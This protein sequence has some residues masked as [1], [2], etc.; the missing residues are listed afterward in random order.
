MEDGE[1]DN[2]EWEPEEQPSC[3]KKMSSKQIG[4]PQ[5]NV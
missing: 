4:H 1:D 2:W 5:L 3:G